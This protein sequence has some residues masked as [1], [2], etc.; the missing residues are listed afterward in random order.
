MGDPAYEALF[1]SA[2]IGLALLDE[3]GAPLV[4]N[5]FCRELLGD[6]AESV[7]REVVAARLGGSDPLEEP[8][9]GLGIGIIGRLT[10]VRPAGGAGRYALAVGRAY[11]VH[12]VVTGLENRDA[13]LNRL[14]HLLSRRSPVRVELVFIDL[15]GFKAV[16]DSLGHAVG[17][18]VLRCVAERLQEVVRPE[19]VVVRW[20]GDEFVVIL[21]DSAEGSAPH[22][23]KRIAEALR[24]PVATSGGPV[25]V[26]ASCGCASG[27]NGD[28]PA[29][30]LHSADLR[31]YEAKRARAH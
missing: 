17:D 16:N 1:H 23:C 18:E 21:E 20:G 26:S 12:D 28:N 19:D 24:E 11:G 31:M 4:V 13:A 10:R 2:A 9:A 15:D 5:A 8:V 25:S 14:Q 29:T 30:L 27:G 22:V 3:H 7:I 6:D